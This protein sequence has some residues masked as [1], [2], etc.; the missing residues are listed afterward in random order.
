MSRKSNKKKKEKKK[1]D[2]NFI[3]FRY[4]FVGHS[5]ENVICLFRVMAQ[6]VTHPSDVVKLR[7]QMTNSTF[8]KTIREILDMKDPRRFYDGLNAALFR[9]LTYTMTKM[10]IYMSTMEFWT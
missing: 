1:R 10:G 4:N 8:I 5:R 2:I 7:M 3:Q 9:Q 6:L